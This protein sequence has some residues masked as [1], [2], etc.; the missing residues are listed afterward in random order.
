MSFPNLIEKFTLNKFVKL[1][2]NFF[3]GVPWGVIDFTDVTLVSVDATEKLS[4]QQE[5]LQPW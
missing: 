2:D 1:Q 5:D 4:Y 3:L